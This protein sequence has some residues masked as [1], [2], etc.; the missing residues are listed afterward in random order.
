MTSRLV[1]M[2]CVLTFNPPVVTQR[3]V[4]QFR[5]PWT[6]CG[7]NRLCTFISL[8]CP[9]HLQHGPS[10]TCSARI[11]TVLLWEIFHHASPYW[12]HGFNSSVLSMRLMLYESH[13]VENKYIDALA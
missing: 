5:L 11:D 7:L 13:V 12:S 2:G 4:D 10:S 6:L 8:S 1:E 3:L 9:C